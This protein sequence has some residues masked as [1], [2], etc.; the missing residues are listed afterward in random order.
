VQFTRNPSG[1]AG[2]LRKIGGLS[3]RSLLEAPAAE[4]ASH[5]FFGQGVPAWTGLLATHPDLGERIRRIE[6]AWDGTFI[7]GVIDTPDDAEP[8]PGNLA[9]GAVGIAA[10]AVAGTPARETSR[11]VACVSQVHLQY[12]A[13]LLKGWP[14]GVVT[15]AREPF[16]ARAVVYALLINAEAD[17]RARQMDEL[18][19]SDPPVAQTVRALLKH[20]DVMPDEE[21]LPLL[22]LAMP[23][24]RRLSAAQ[25]R[26]FR[27]MVE[28]LVR[29]DGKIQLFEWMVERLVI[30][31]LRQ[32]FAKTAP[33]RARYYGLGQLTRECSILLSTL[34]RAGA[35]SGSLARRA[36][37]AGAACLEGVGSSLEF[38]PA[39]ACRLCELNT[40]LETLNETAP[41]LK[42]QLVNA[43]GA[44]ILADAEVTAREAELLRAVSATL[45]CPIPPLIAGSEE[46]Q[47]EPASADGG[48]S[49]LQ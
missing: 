39:E 26:Q 11:R 37:A 7:S 20:I 45:N 24:L 44:T 21:R 38:L 8:G 27:G 41:R 9:E 48:A 33:Q 34:A 1:L 43:C 36:F 42:Q 49:A 13:R 35:R 3:R 17:S 25:Y 29:A 15:A 6:P 14:L 22:D 23:A 28:L 19:G 4:S 47:E 31:N 32:Q 18:E 5:M 46:G 12:A 40:A 30:S 2:A 10:G 16:S